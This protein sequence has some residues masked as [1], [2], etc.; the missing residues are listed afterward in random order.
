MK[1]YSFLFSVIFSIVII[2]CDSGEKISIE[3]SPNIDETYVYEVSG[4]SNRT[5][6]DE[7][8]FMNQYYTFTM[9]FLESSPEGFPA[10]VT[11]QEFGIDTPDSDMYE[12]MFMSVFESIKSDTSQFTLKKSGSISYQSKITEESE[13]DMQMNFEDPDAY[14]KT[15]TKQMKENLLANLF[16]EWIPYTTSDSVSI[17]SKWSTVTDLSMMGLSEIERTIE[18]QV[19]KFDNDFIY[20]KAKSKLSDFSFPM[21]MGMGQE[22]V[23]NFA[24]FI[25]SNYDYQLD[26]NTRMIRNA[27]INITTDGTISNSGDNLEEEDKMSESLKGVAK[28]TI[29]RK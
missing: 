9:N 28:T 21:D 24:G 5:F 1:I 2:S 23:L 7:E 11:F 14:I 26:R 19:D 25:E 13:E 4:E 12:D 10:L 29:S 18:W 3:L 27:T 6:T 17:K 15:M 8:S 22:M 20:L 16:S